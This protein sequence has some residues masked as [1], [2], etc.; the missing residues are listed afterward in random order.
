MDEHLGSS[1]AHEQH[2]PPQGV[3][4]AVELF[5]PQRVKK[6]GENVADVPVD[7]LQGHVQ[8]QPGRLVHEGLQAP[9]VCWEER[10][11]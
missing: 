2:G 8:T 1:R 11:G 9:D 7:P 4:V 6:I 5:G 3:P 10:G